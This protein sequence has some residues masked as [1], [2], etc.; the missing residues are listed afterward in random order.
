M[1]AGDTVTLA[2]L[3]PPGFHVYEVP[4]SADNE[5]VCPAQI[6]DVP[7]ADIVGIGTTVTVTVFVEEQ[8]PLEAVTV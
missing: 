8:V 6:V 2:P 1:A 7:D 5:A 3:K 4:P